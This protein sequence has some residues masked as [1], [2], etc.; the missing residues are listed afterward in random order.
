MSKTK[1]QKKLIIVESPTKSKTISH[2]LGDEFLI[3]SSYGHIRNLPKSNKKAIDIKAGFIPHYEITKGKEDVVSKIKSLAKNSSEVLLAT[4]PDREGE[5]IAWHL[6]ETCGLKNPKRI[7]FHEITENAI[8]EA[9]NHPREIDENLRQAQEARRV[10]DRLVGYDLSGL[11]WKKVRYGLSAGRVQSPALRIIM[12]REREIRAFIPENYW[13]LT[14]E[15]QTEK[16][17][18]STPSTS[19]E[20]ASSA[21]DKIILTCDKEPADEKETNRILEAGRANPWHIAEIKQTE[22]KRSPRAPFTTSTLQQ[23]ASSRLGF[24]PSR[25]MMVAQK[26]YE[27][28]L[29]TYMRTDSVIISKEALP[30]I[31]QEIEKT[32]GKKYL[33]PR[34][35]K[36]KSKS[37]QE[38]HEAIRPTN[39]GL[40]SAG[41]NEEQER[42]YGLIWARTISSQMTDAKM[43]RTKIS[44]N[45]NKEGIIPNF[46][47]VGSI[48]VFPGWLAADVE[49]Q[50]EEVQIPKLSKDEKLELLNLESQGKQTEPPGRYTE[51]GLVKELE[52][53]EIGRPS[54]YAYII[55]TIN[56]RGYVTKDGKTLHPTD[57]G[58]VVS[59]FLENNFPKYISDSFTAE[60]EN[61]LDEIAE[62]KIKYEKVLKDFYGPFSKDVK[63]KEKI[64]KVTNLGDAD[65]KFKCPVCNGPMVIKLSKTG[66]FLSCAKFPECAGAR[67]ADGSIMEGPKETGEM[68]PECSTGKLVEREGRFGK[69]IFCSNYPKCKFIKRSAEEEAKAKTGVKCPKCEGEIVERRGRFGPFFSCSNYPKCKFIIKSRPTGKTCDLCG[70]LMMQGTKTIPERCSNKACS[71]HNPHKSQK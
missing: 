18:A 11:I 44:A 71:M 53:R 12:E 68:C 37:A 51:A 32:F 10:L 36:T 52:K 28:G 19:S 14:G 27:Q 13:V 26:L 17:D 20:Q 24:S 56:D 46:S 67:K 6:K 2:F 29:I 64:D 3:E 62:G 39:I 8:K 60:M 7:V 1:N 38:A 45:I 54:T 35:Y 70:S 47:V 48:T 34:I 65:E 69:F 9:I 25:T 41:I 57:T 59:D 33:E 40:K 43:L 50:G 30:V 21:Q 5:A 58:E 16:K 22:A 23:T 49:A 42:L 63:S 4:D 31:H 15:F 55:K 66:K 61:E